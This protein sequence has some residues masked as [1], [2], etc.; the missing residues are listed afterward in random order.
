ML[1]PL[2]TVGGE[3][4]VG[5]KFD[6]GGRFDLRLPY[7]E[8][9]SYN[10]LGTSFFRIF[11]QYSTMHVLSLLA[12][13]YRAMLMKRARTTATPSQTFLVVERRRRKRRYRL[14]KRFQR[15]KSRRRMDFGL[16][17]KQWCR[18]CLRNE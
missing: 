8:Q 9:V 1:W 10:K 11:V 17:N 12:T 15:T 14:L 18:L 6:N 7:A 16:F 5:G 2:R 4:G 13:V 3:F